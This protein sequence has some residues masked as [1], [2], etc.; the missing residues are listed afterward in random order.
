MAL[1]QLY[2]SHGVYQPGKPGIPIEFEN[3]YENLENLW[4]FAVTYGTF[5]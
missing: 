3:T 5:G 2:H 4:I 1:P